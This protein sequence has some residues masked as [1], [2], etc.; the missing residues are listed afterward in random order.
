M[1]VFV[2]ILLPLI[3]YMLG[4][5]SNAVWISKIF[6]KMD[7]RQH[8]SKNAGTT[9]TLR[10]LGPKAA[11]PV[12][13]FDMLK[14]IL[15]VLLIHFTHLVK[16]SEAYTGYEIFL[17][18]C[19]VV[20]HIFPLFAGFK[21]GKG[22]AT[23]AGCL[24]AINPAAMSLALGVFIICLIF[25][26]YVSLSSISAA[27]I[28]PFIVIIVLGLWLRPESV[29]LTMKIFSGIVTILILITHRKNIKR[30]LNGTEPKISFK[31]KNF[32]K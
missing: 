19:A 15:S 17:S 8:G 13:I 16:Y 23:M 32:N 14:G 29:T 25:S 26:G 18:I 12:F 24:L 22:V 1:N 30:L 3:A 21:G 6:H 11:L 2:A 20:G 9:N 31:K 28:F 10:I 7:I 5:I 27:I 4:S